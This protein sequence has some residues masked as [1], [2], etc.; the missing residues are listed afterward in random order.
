MGIL[1]GYMLQNPVIPDA[2]ILIFAT[3]FLG[4]FTTFSTFALEVQILLKKPF[5]NIVIYLLLQLA[6]AMLLAAGGMFI[7]SKFTGGT[8]G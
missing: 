4:S 7:G 5:T 3:G 6:A 8:F 1:F 2:F